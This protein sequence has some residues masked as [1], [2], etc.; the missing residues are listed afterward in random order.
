VLT[1]DRV[2]TADAGTYSVR[3]SNILGSTLSGDAVFEVTSSPPLIAM[4]PTNQTVA[5][6][7]TVAFTVTALGN[8]PLSYQWQK[9]GTNLTDGGGVSGSS[10]PALTL[11]N[12]TE[13]ANGTYAVIVSNVLGSV[14]SSGAVLSVIPVSAPGTRL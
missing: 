7:A 14:S 9:N 4:Q 1:L 12:V 2:T 8:L 13:V 10:T 11:N 5:P 6:G 3:V